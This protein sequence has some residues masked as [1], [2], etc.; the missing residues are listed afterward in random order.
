M[1]LAKVKF[2]IEGMEKLQKS[3][4]KLGDVPQKHVTTAARK[5]MNIVKKQAKAD[6]PYLSGDLQRGIISVAEKTKVKGKKVYRIVFDRAMNDVFQHKAQGA[7]FRYVTVKGKAVKRA[8]KAGDVTGYYPVS[9][10]YGYFSRGGR[11]IPGF[12]FTRK[13]LESKAPAVEKTIVE[14]MKKKIDA[15]IAKGGLKK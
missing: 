4:K 5:G 7:G 13:A 10:E 6:A 14:I 3:L 1:I 2:K 8:V 12:A 9:Q 15:E 11:Y